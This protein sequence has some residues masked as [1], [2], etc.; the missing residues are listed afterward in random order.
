MCSS[1]TQ[2][3]AVKRKV[4][5][6]SIKSLLYVS[7]FQSHKGFTSPCLLSFSL[8]IV[9]LFSLFTSRGFCSPESWGK[10]ALL[11]EDKFESKSL[12]NWKPELQKP[13]LSVVKA[14]DGKLNIDVGGG[15]SIWFKH[16]LQGNILIEYDVVVIKKEGANDR[17]SDLNQFWMASDPANTNLFTR[18]GD[19]S[20]YDNL[21]LYYVGV[22]G[23]DN[24]T[25]RFRRY[26]GGGD[27]PLLGEFTDAKHLLK[28]DTNYHIEIICFDGTTQFRVNGETLFNY[29]DKEPLT[30]GHFGFRTVRNH[31]TVDNFKVHRLVATGIVLPG[32]SIQE[33]IDAVSAD[34]G[35][36]VT[37]AAGVHNISS[38]LR[39]RSNVTLQGEGERASTLKTTSD[40]KM[41]IQS[42][43][44]M[45]N[46]TIR[47]LILV[48]S[49]TVKAGGIHLIA[50]RRD[51]EGITLSGVHVFE[52]GWGVHIKGAKNVIIENCDFSKNGTSSRK[53][54]AH[55]LYLRRCY[56]AK[57]SDSVFRD[58]ISGNG[59]NIS[60][61]RDINIENCQATGNYFRGMRAADTDGFRVHNCVLSDNGDRGLY[62]NKEKTVTKN[63]D[64]ENNLVSNNGKRGISANSGVTGSCK[65]NNSFGNGRDYDIART[66]SQSGNVSDS[67]VDKKTDGDR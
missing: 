49:P 34:G 62:A 36:T 50:S 16:K 38:P 12:N 23:N 17:L 40:I 39:I 7:T 27:R 25:T 42:G 3:V 35:G 61:S 33:A 65:N 47:N 30:E 28:P 10:G 63:I 67:S 44:G 2:Y 4:N 57:V 59:I 48:G 5:T 45:K 9:A 8:V 31:E 26:P 46:V 53:G 52:T 1:L 56:T 19:F 54:Y 58:S 15:A 37:L 64:W 66:V 13:D 24:S 29:K 18:N 41:I 60:Y 32:E 20:E 6:M 21:R 55:N 22:G 14:Q 11:Y 43:D 51:H